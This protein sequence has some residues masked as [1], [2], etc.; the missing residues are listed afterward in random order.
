MIHIC[1]YFLYLQ[2]Q[3]SMLNPQEVDTLLRKCPLWAVQLWCAVGRHSSLSALAVISEGNK[4][5]VGGLV[6]AWFT[7]CFW[8]LPAW[9]STQTAVS[10]HPSS[11]C[12]SSRARHRNLVN[13]H[14]GHV[15]FSCSD[16]REKEF[17]TKRLHINMKIARWDTNLT[18]FAVL[19]CTRSTYTVE[20]GNFHK[21]FLN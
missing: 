3:C 13:N 20:D 4:W 12:S 14:A 16:L 6:P 15:W 17:G 2:A 1:T 21:G 5:P 8:R 7:N 10:S 11:K 19:F 18:R 9:R